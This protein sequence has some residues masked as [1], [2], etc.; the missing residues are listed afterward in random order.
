[1]RTPVYAAI[2][3]LA[4]GLLAAPTAWAEDG[5]P[6]NDITK[7]IKA[8]MEEILR[9]M[10]ANEDALLSLSA[11]EDGAPKKV[12]VKVPNPPAE[13]GNAPESGG[14]SGASGE[15]GSSGSE[16]ETEAG[17]SGRAAVKKIEELL[18]AQQAGSKKIPGELQ[19]L[20]EM[21]PT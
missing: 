9:L 17:A 8:Q 1:M 7:E 13:S 12:D 19:K 16:G 5:A 3:A 15:S 20:L 6:E 18:G 11:G 14:E 10:K 2:L 4:L 21:I